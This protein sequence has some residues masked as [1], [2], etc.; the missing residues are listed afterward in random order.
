M[1]VGACCSGS[2]TVTG[3][4]TGW[5]LQVLTVGVAGPLPFLGL[6]PVQVIHDLAVEG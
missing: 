2:R 1:P 3:A 4:G 5:W 6:S